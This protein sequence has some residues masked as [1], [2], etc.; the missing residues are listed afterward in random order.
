[1]PLGNLLYL[2][3]PSC[4]SPYERSL[5]HIP[6]VLTC[7]V[8]GEK[9][10]REVALESAR[11]Y[12]HAVE[13]GEIPAFLIIDNFEVAC[14]ALDNAPFLGFRIQE[15]V[16]VRGYAITPSWRFMGGFLDSNKRMHLDLAVLPAEL[17]KIS[18]TSEHLTG[19]VLQP[20]S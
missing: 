2:P 8:L 9:R 3:I 13:R 12:H 18:Q 4:I 7:S 6:H 16:R 19:Y 5:L 1:M 20:P 10:L 15:E 14:L 17:S 11:E